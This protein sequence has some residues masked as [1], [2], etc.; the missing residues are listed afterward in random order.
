MNLGITN[1]HLYT[2]FRIKTNFCLREGNEKILNGTCFFVKNSREQ[3]CL[4]TNRH[5]FELCYSG[6]GK[7]VGSVL[8]SV[9]IEGYMALDGN[10]DNVPR[11]RISFKILN[12][13]DVTYAGDYH[14][15]V[16]CIVNP[17]P[18]PEQGCNQNIKLDYFLGYEYL[19]D[20]K[21]IHDFVSVYDFLVYPGF[22]DWHDKLE[23][24][25]ILRTGTISSDPRT[26]YSNK[27]EP[28]GR[29][30]VYEGFSFRGSSG[31][32]MFVTEKGI[33]AGKGLIGGGFRESRLIGINA[34]HL[35]GDFG[36]HSG[37]SYF[38]KSSAILELVDKLA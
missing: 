21:W 22:P 26:N 35:I 2:A 34:G 33:K 19:A 15:D 16:A 7:Y 30:V 28:R 29:R 27:N 5:I 12:F 38:I 18:E 10:I 4:I 6:T 14:E 17:L 37:V 9:I 31:S 11:G 36:Q 24:R 23:N 8:Q 32:P 3:L 25:P 20:D 13:S 1:A